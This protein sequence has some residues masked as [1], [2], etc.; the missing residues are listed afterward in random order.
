[1]DADA[2]DGLTFLVC[3]LVGEA[4]TPWDVEKVDAAFMAGIVDWGSCW[5][6]AEVRGMFIGAPSSWK[7]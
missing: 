4:T 7:T 6:D 3:R 5:F 2:G 1:M